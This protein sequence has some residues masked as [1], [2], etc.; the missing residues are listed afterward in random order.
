MDYRRVLNMSLVI[1][2]VIFVPALIALL[3]TSF[4]PDTC[5]KN[6]IVFP[7]GTSQMDFDNLISTNMIIYA[8]IL[9]FLFLVILVNYLSG[10]IAEDDKE[11]FGF[12]SFLDIFA[13]INTLFSCLTIFDFERT[14]KIKHFYCEDSTIEHNLYQNQINWVILLMNQLCPL[15]YILIKINKHPFVKNNTGPSC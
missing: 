8:T 5:I 9:F 4:F 3:K 12:V 7:N 13:Y 10:F 2:F 11:A 1:D 15:H 14:A 6:Q